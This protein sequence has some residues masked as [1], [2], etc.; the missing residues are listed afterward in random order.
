MVG[1][2]YKHVFNNIILPKGGTLNTATTSTL[3][4]VEL[5]LGALGITTRGDCYHDFLFG[6]EIFVGDITVPGNKV[7]ASIVAEFI[8]DLLQLLGDN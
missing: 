3:R 2:C 7:S 6:Y 8:G 1:T 4:P 5:T